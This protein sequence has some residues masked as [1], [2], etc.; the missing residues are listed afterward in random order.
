MFLHQKHKFKNKKN[1]IYSKNLKNKRCELQSSNFW[2]KKKYKIFWRRRKTFKKNQNLRI[3]I[4]DSKSENWN[5]K[6]KIEISKKWKISIKKNQQ[7]NKKSI[8]NF[9]WGSLKG[10]LGDEGVVVGVQGGKITNITFRHEG[11]TNIICHWNLTKNNFSTNKS[12]NFDF[13]LKKKE[14]RFSYLFSENLRFFKI[15]FFLQKFQYFSDFEIWEFFFQ[16]LRNFS[17]FKSS[18]FF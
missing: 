10:Y 17:Y 16:V 1:N 15:S 12:W 5:P 3:D 2:Q 7:K 14:F 9:I 18:D 6:T 13:G 8:R 4:W 11:V